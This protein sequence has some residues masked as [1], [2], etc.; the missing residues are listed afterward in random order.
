MTLSRQRLSLLIGCAT[1]LAAWVAAACFSERP[2]G[3]SGINPGVGNC[4][5]PLSVIDSGH[6]VVAINNFVFARDS[7]LIPVGATV[8]WVNC[9]PDETEPHTTTADGSAWG[10]PELNPGARFSHTFGAAGTFPYH[11]EPHPF[12][13]GK[14]VVQ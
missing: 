10:S 1:A 12:M 9:E 11:C 6:V 3:P 2:G 13:V 5:V 4:R 7:I 14:V 8:T